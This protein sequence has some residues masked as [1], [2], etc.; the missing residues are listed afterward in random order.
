M[1][2]EPPSNSE[3]ERTPLPFEPAKRRKKSTVSASQSEKPREPASR[4]Q[5][6]VAEEA[7]ATASQTQAATGKQANSPESTAIPQVVS[8]RMASRMAVFCGVPTSMGIGTFFLSYLI[9]VNHWFKL[10]NIAVILVSMGFFGLGVLGLS[11]GVLSASWDE[12]TPGSKL[13][14]AEFTENFGR[15]RQSWQASKQKDS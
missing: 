13:G 9:V 8:R 14:W 5:N 11:Y 7:K 1:A 3:A 4:S 10:P 12:E 6:R 2:S 15:L